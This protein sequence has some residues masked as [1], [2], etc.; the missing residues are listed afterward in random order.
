MFGIGLTEL[1]VILLIAMVVVG[2]ERMPE[3][4]RSVG[5]GIRD[6]RRMYDNL[7]S[8]LGPDYDDIEQAIRTLRSVNPRHELNSYTRKF[9]DNLADEATPGGSAVM[10]SSPEQL[11]ESLRQ[12]IAA[13]PAAP[14]AN[15][16]STANGHVN[17]PPASTSAG[18][19]WEEASAAHDRP[20]VAAPTPSADVAKLGQ[21]LLNDDLL[22]S[23]LADE[24]N[25][26]APSG[27]RSH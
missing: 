16:D 22:D 25:K 14:A 21:E 15:G 11:S 27:P 7:R 13:P 4:A 8:D 6:L 17:T 2:P 18:G 24:Q 12:T 26:A 19:A 23:L 3:L 10:H 5:K 20:G 1:L 9:L